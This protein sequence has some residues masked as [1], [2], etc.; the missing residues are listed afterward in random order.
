MSVTLF[1][2]RQDTD[3]FLQDKR[4]RNPITPGKV[5]DYSALDSSP[6]GPRSAKRQRSELKLGNEQAD[7]KTSGS[8]CDG[9]NP[10]SSGSVTE[11]EPVL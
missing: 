6:L 7:D 11:G 5:F 3:E 8:R 9:Q 1:Y 4:K 2:C 10:T